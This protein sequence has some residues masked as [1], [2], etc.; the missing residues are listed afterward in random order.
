M[1]VVRIAEVERQRREGGF[2]GSQPF[3]GQAE[4]QTVEIPA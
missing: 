4:S 2:P 3:Q 1:A